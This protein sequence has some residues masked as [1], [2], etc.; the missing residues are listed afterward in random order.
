MKTIVITGA[1]GFIGMALC[2]VFHEAGWRVFGGVREPERHHTKFFHPFRCDLPDS[3]SQSPFQDADVCIHAAWTMIWRT[4]RDAL[5]TNIKG[6]AH[7]LRLCRK[8]GCRFVFLSSCSAHNQAESL[9]GRT[10]LA[11]EQR[12]DPAR[13]LIVRPGFVIG[14]GSVFSRMRDALVGSR[15]VPLF[16]GGHGPLQTIHIDDLCHFVR[17]AVQK[18][19]TG[20]LVAAEAEGTC[21]RTFLRELAHAS[22]RR[23]L[24]IPVPSAITLPFVQLAEFARLP[25]PLSSE[26]LKGLR[27]LVYQPSRSDIRRVGI[28]IRSW[29]ESLSTMP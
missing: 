3:V 22:G 8:H 1:S 28:R 10:K 23:P 13:D 16:D 24:F 29:R 17:A 5:R 19:I 11:V 4:R 9:Y 27:G 21:L 12:L 20:R 15:I 6:T 26:N 18:K 25:L 14:N 2:R 7:V